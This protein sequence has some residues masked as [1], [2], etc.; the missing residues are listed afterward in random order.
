MLSNIRATALSALVACASTN[1]RTTEETTMTTD[2]ARTVRRY[3]D[4]MWNRGDTKVVDELM[5]DDVV[6]HVN[7][8][9]IHGREVLRQRIAVLW[10]AYSDLRF[11]VQDVVVAD[12]RA[13]VRWTFRGR[14]TGALYGSPGTGRSVAI[15]GM[16]MFRLA[17]SRIA[18]VWVSADDL[19]ELEQLGLIRVPTGAGQ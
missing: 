19:G 15:T 4:D 5:A 1:A 2:N 3:F 7:N 18:E 17:D 10:S 12:D 8:I 16:N 9:T 6:G 11:D 13:V 14:H